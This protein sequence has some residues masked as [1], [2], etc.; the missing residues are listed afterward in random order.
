MGRKLRRI[1]A[2]YYRYGL[3][4]YNWYGLF[5][6]PSRFFTEPYYRVKWF[7]QRGYRGYADCDVWNMNSWLCR[8]MIPMLEELDRNA[9]GYP[10][11]LTPGK[12]R[13]ILENLGQ[14]FR[15]AQRVLDPDDFDVQKA[16]ADQRY[17]RKYIKL[18]GKYFFNLWD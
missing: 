18:F 9:H 12:W 16:R 3:W 4:G 10:I 13:D 8:V 1:D 14:A 2:W 6:R 17:F 7:I 11:G 15:A 5:T